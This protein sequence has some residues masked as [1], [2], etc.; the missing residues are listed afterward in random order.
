M[1]DETGCTDTPKRVRN[2]GFG[3]ALREAAEKVR[4][5]RNWRV[6]TRRDGRAIRGV[7]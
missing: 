2:S 6:V 4:P 1:I 7:G 3:R 5:A